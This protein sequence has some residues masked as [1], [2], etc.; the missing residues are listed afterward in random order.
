VQKRKMRTMKRK[1]LLICVSVSL[2]VVG[3]WLLTSGLARAADQRLGLRPTDNPLGVPG[4]VLTTTLRLVGPDGETLLSPPVF[5]VRVSEP[6]S[7]S[8]YVRNLLPRAVSIVAERV[9]I[10]S[11]DGASVPG[12]LGLSPISQTVAADKVGTFTL[13]LVEGWLPAGTYSGMLELSAEGT[14]PATEQFVLLVSP[15]PAE[16]EWAQEE[17]VYVAD[18]AHTEAAIRVVARHADAENIQAEL[19]TLT[20]GDNMTVP[21]K[22]ADFLSITPPPT[23]T[24]DTVSKVTLNFTPAQLPMPGTYNGKLQLSASNAAPITASFTLVVPD[25]ARGSYRLVVA[26]LG[27][28]P[29]ITTPTSLTLTTALQFTGVRWLPASASTASWWPV[30]AAALLFGVGLA[31]LTGYTVWGVGGPAPKAE[32][33]VKG[34]WQK[35]GKWLQKVWTLAAGHPKVS[36]GLMAVTLALVVGG[37]SLKLDLTQT[38]VGDRNL[39]IWEVEGRGPVREMRVLGGEVVNQVGDWGQIRIGDHDGEIAAQDIL[40]VPVTGIQGLSQPGVYQG[41]ILIQSPDIAGGL[42]Q[43]PVQVTVHDLIFWPALVILLGVVAGG[44]MKYLQ[45][46]VGGRLEQRRK[47]QEAWSQWN[48]HLDRDPYGETKG[49]INPLYTRIRTHINVTEQLLGLD[50]EWGIEAARETVTSVGKDFTDYSTLVNRFTLL[51]EEMRSLDVSAAEATFQR[52]RPILDSFLAEIEELKQRLPDKQREL[53]QLEEAVEAVPQSL[54]LEFHTHVKAESDDLD[55]ELRDGKLG[56]ANQRWH[57][58]FEIA[59]KVKLAY[60]RNRMTAWAQGDAV[61][62]ERLKPAEDQLASVDEY[63]KKVTESPELYAEAWCP[64]IQAEAVFVSEKAERL[65]DQV[66]G[67][68]KAARELKDAKIEEREAIPIETTKLFAHVPMLLRGREVYAPEVL[69]ALVS[70]PKPFPLKRVEPAI[71]VQESEPYLWSDIENRQ[72]TCR[73]NLQARGFGKDPTWE[74]KLVPGRFKPSQPTEGGKGFDW[75]NEFTL[76]AEDWDGSPVTYVVEASGDE[77]VAKKAITIRSPYTIELPLRKGDIVAGEW[78][79]C[80][81]IFKGPDPEEARKKHCYFTW[82]FN[83]S[84]LEPKETPSGRFWVPFDYAGKSARIQLQVLSDKNALLQKALFEGRVQ[85]PIIIGLYRDKRRHNFNRRLAALLLA[86][87]GG[88]A[89]QRVFGLTFGSFEEYLGAFAWGVG[90]ATGIDPVANGYKGLK[91]KV[92]DLLKLGSKS[93][94]PSSSQTGQ[95]A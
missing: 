14:Q 82:E 80:E 72:V 48:T 51:K 74:Y 37:L 90:A 38:H 73:L 12:M 13:S 95:P 42:V 50:P 16:L 17:F 10:S 59:L 29:P 36:L 68:M 69:K 83:G 89:A 28:S 86:L 67:F 52:A 30:V 6:L 94:Q 49:R 19:A 23:L 8:L 84:S 33:K 18:A 54:P 87:V 57:R 24:K 4:A 78:L 9:E 11:A 62:L 45:D 43:V 21:F 58:A 65:A 20:A 71:A 32:A 41:R 75:A 47:L 25:R 66:N 61:L 88:M 31:V 60:L 93:E 7:R 34:W 3:L 27:Q 1:I 44:W 91:D 85:E 53:E 22:T 35:V 64:L 2:A 63:L 79:F 55:K 5:C 76:R 40:A 70:L 26:E 56:E 15:W 92:Q 39:L 46:M 81:A 77:Q